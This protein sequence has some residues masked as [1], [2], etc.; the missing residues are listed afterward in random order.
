MLSRSPA[1]LFSGPALLVEAIRPSVRTSL[2]ALDVQIWGQIGVEQRADPLVGDCPRVLER[3]GSEG[4]SMEDLPYEMK[5]DLQ[6][7]KPAQVV[8]QA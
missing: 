3:D 2:V 7:V 4:K 6:K 8:W 5:T 1:T